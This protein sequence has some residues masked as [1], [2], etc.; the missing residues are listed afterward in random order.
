MAKDPSNRQKLSATA[1]M[2]RIAAG[3][4]EE[5]EVQP[6][7]DSRG[8]ELMDGEIRVDR[9]AGG[10]PGGPAMSAQRQAECCESSFGV[11]K[12]RKAEHLQSSSPKREIVNAGNATQADVHCALLVSQ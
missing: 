8:A 1:L 6:W 12:E 5:S 7:E 3:L 9:R 2:K 10:E 4:L 11:I